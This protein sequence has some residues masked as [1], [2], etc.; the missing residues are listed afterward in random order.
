MRQ[1]T[2]LTT[3]QT[4]TEKVAASLGEQLKGGEVI[5][6][7]GDVGAGKTTFV[8]GLARGSGSVDRVSSPTFTVSQLYRSPRVTIHH[9][10]FYRLDDIAIMREELSEV[11][12][13]PQAMVVLEW[14]D[15]LQDVLPDERVTI[16][17][18]AKGETEREIQCNI[19]ASYNYL[20]IIE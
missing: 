5:E 17:L 18:K 8:R 19:P 10:D 1:I 14:A 20:E 4:A 13:D 6:L 11:L 15:S 12:E 2:L 7:I 9:Y 16:N 3:D